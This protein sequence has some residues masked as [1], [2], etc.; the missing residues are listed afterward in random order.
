MFS[1]H[2]LEIAPRAAV[3]VSTQV[4]RL[5]TEHSYKWKYEGNK[6]QFGFNTELVEE[7]EQLQ[8]ALEKVKPDYAR[9][10]TSALKQKVVRRNKLIKIADSSEGGRETVRQYEANPI[11]SDSEDEG[12]INR[13][14][15]RAIKRRKV[16][17]SASK[18]QHSGRGAGYN[19]GFG[20][21]HGN[22]QHPFRA[23]GAGVVFRSISI[24][25][26]RNTLP[27]QGSAGG[28]FSCGSPNYWRNECP[29]NQ[30]SYLTAAARKAKP[31]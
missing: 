22:I 5:K 10:I 27:S 24:T 11:A 8:W 28:C 6:V 15:N 7:F 26:N 13:A 4:K 3:S 23:P 25:G 9:E 1:F 14:E 30:R 31:E 19:M 17:Q 16:K 18:K 2:S 29:S 21:S 20:G 12:R